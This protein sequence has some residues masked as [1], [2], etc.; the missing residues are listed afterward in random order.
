MGKQKNIL[1]FEECE[2]IEELD[3]D[4]TDGMVAGIAAAAALAGLFVALT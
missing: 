4:F 1:K 3:H 2:M